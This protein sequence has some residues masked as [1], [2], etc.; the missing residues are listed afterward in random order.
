MDVVHE[1]D[2]VD[3][4]PIGRKSL[5]DQNS[6]MIDHKLNDDFRS[7]II[8]RVTQEEHKLWYKQTFQNP[9]D[10]ATPL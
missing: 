3:P 8:F 9:L 6:I 5:F 4:V 2:K 10:D 1:D 7:H